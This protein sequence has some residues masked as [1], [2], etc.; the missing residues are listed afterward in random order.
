V[1]TDDRNIVE[2]GFARS[3]GA[4]GVLTNELRDVAR[5]IGDG[6][7]TLADAAAIDWS[8]VETARISFLAAES[9]AAAAGSSSDGPPEELARRAA[10]VSYYGRSDLPAARA[11]WAGRRE[12]PRDPAEAAM[13]ADFE[14]DAGADDAMAAIERLRAFDGGEADTILAALRL[15]H[16]DVDGAAAALE[17]A[18]RGFRT[19]PW[20]AF[21]YKL[22]ALVLAN[23]VEAQSRCGSPDVRRARRALLGS[24][25]GSR[26]PDGGR[27]HQS[28]VRVQGSM[29]GRRGRIGAARTVGRE[30]SR[31]AA[32]L[33]PGGGRPAR[34]ARGA[35]VERV[36][37]GGAAGAR[38]RP[39]IANAVALPE[40]ALH[41]RRDASRISVS[42]APAAFARW[43]GQVGSFVRRRIAAARRLM[44]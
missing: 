4:S 40:A 20:A 29:R 26:S 35:R 27:D 16:S 34:R 41:R 8:V 13:V 28:T 5:A 31:A 7:P 37:V 17:S 12:A 10:L 11:A 44:V 15:R 6:R 9:Y 38:E 19:S 43:S 1:N 33:L 18:F 14:A 39:P 30:V 22:N 36:S 2:Y 23:L 3:M 25:D 42:I 24:R 32:R 21:R